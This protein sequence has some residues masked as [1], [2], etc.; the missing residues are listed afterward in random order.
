MPNA[1]INGLALHYEVSGPDDGR[2]LLLSNSLASDLH[3]WDAQVDAL[4]AAGFRVLRYD[5]RGHGRSA[6]PPGPL[7]IEQLAD[8]VAALLDHL[9]WDAVDYCG[10]SLGGM[11]GQMTARRHPGRLRS[12][13]LA[14]TAAHMGPPALWNDRIAAVEAGGMAAVVEA[15]LGRWFTA[16]AR[17]GT[18]HA[19]AIAAVR[20]AILATSPAGFCA[21][22]AAIRDMDQRADIA[23]ITLPTLV[24]VGAEDPSTPVAAAELIHARIAGSRLVVLPDAAHLANIEQ[25]AAFNAAL[26]E[27]LAGLA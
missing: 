12:L 3:M 4:H 20:A 27:F 9:G 24:V 22:S 23:A 5:N 1:L 8:D 17:A 16:A 7:S 25:A 26:L 14:D 10:L 18:T 2:A 11:I 15:T 6:P 19:A 21:C 13:V